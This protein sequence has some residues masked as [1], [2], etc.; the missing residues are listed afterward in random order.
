VKEEGEMNPPK[1]EEAITPEE[2]KKR[3]KKLFTSAEE[4]GQA[5]LHLFRSRMV[6]ADDKRK[7]F[8]DQLLKDDRTSLYEV[9]RYLGED[10]R[11]RL[12]VYIDDVYAYMQDPLVAEVT[13]GIGID[14]V[15]VKWEPGL[16]D[17][18]TSARLAVVD[19]NADTGNVQPAAKW[20]EN[21][22]KKIHRF[23]DPNGE[24]LGPSKRKSLQFH[25]VNVWAVVQ[26]VLNMY[27]SPFAL[28]RPIPWGTGG[29]RLYIVPH[30]GYAENAYY[31]RHSKSLQ[32]YY[33]GSDD[34]PKYTCLS[35]DIVAHETGH[36]ILDGIRPNYYEFT[37][38]ETSAFHEF[39][40]DLT[41]IMAGLRQTSVR[42]ETARVTEGDLTRKNVIG[43]IAEEFGGVVLGRDALRNADNELNM[44]SDE[45]RGSYIPHDWSRVLTGAMYDILVEIARKHLEEVREDGSRASPLQALWW[46]AQ[47]FGRIALQ[48]LDFCPPADI[49]F[50]DYA[51]AVLHNFRLYEPAD[52]PKRSEYEELIRRV[53]HERKI[54]CGSDEE[55]ES[56]GL[57]EIE[58]PR[59]W[60]VYHDIDDIS[61]SR[62]GAYYFLND[63]RRILHIPPYQDIT[64]LDL[65]DTSKYGREASRLPREIVLQYIWREEFVLEGSEFGHLRGRTAE[66]LCGGTLVLDGRGNVLSWSRKPGADEDAGKERLGEL[67]RHIVEQFDRGMIGLRGDGEVDVYGPWTPGVVADTSGGVVRLE[68]TPNLHNPVHGYTKADGSHVAPEDDRLWD[69]REDEWRTNF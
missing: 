65:Y 21:W 16:G 62:I 61:R 24:P 3:F 7:V 8:R 15:F 17:G 42:K 14:K 47:R 35:H 37:S 29:T 12:G 64:V 27:E 31:D 56:C 19:F 10:T 1:S 25:Q 11:K 59:R 6:K 49:R 67:K 32:F 2:A 5:I 4:R 26:N 23:E 45:L 13:P 48:P 51:R 52:S 66:L 53:F 41:A 39:V 30:A 34:D 68:M 54:C 36:A 60:D 57:D 69:G 18:P 22:R 28:G 50:I 40:A 33:Y 20:R 43:L 38:L 63:N 9:S 58:M 46:A 55:V 44:E